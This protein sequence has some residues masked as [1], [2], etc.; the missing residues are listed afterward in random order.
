MGQPHRCYAHRDQNPT[1]GRRP[2][3]RN[4]DFTLI[5]ITTIYLL[6]LFAVL[7]R[8]F[9][10][11]LYDRYVLRGVRPTASSS[12]KSSRAVAAAVLAC[13]I[14]I[15]L[16]LFLTNPARSQYVPESP[17][18]NTAVI[19]VEDWIGLLSLSTTGVVLWLFPAAVVTKVSRRTI[20]VSV[21]DGSKRKIYTFVRVLGTLFMIGAVLIARQLW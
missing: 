4:M 9:A 17:A 19:R 14:F 2:Q 6:L 20:D 10:P 21:A 12:G 18:S 7:L 1:K 5:W 16:H 11:G 13:L 15:P 8:L 3:W